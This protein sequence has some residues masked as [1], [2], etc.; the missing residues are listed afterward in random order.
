MFDKEKIKRAQDGDLKIIEEICSSTWESVYR[1]VYFRVQNREEA[2]DITQETYVK[3]ISY[4][5]RN[6]IKVDKYDSFLK[7]VSLNILRDRWRRNK[8]R[9]VSVNLETINPEKMA[10]EDSTEITI[11]QTLVRNAL[12][13]LNE[14]QKRVVELRILKGYS[15]AETAIMMKKNESS[16]RVLQYRALQKLAAIL[17]DKIV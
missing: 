17:K 11:L 5:Q 15:V 10:I 4:F 7:T 9:G 8:R 6:K 1:F 14:E 3:A 12:D 13:K 16:I 2:E